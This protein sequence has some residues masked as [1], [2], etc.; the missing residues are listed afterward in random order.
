MH[1]RTFIDLFEADIS[2]L[3][4]DIIG[5]VRQTQDAQLLDKIYTVLNQSG[6]AERINGTLE[7]DTDTKG[8]TDTITQ[9]I[10]DTPG[11]FQQKHDFINGFPTGYVDIDKM[12]SGNR[13]KFTELLSGGKFVVDVFNRL[14][15]ETFGSAKGP[16]EFALAVMSPHIKINGKGDLTIGKNTIEV[17]ASAGKEASSGGG[18][19][20][21]P[22]LIRTDDVANIIQSTLKVQL[23]DV[24]PQG[25]G[26][27]GLGK[28]SSKLS[29]SQRR[30]FGKKLFGYMFGGSGADISDLVGAFASGTDLRDAYVKTNYNAYKSESDFD[31]VMIMNFALGELHYFRD[32]NDLVRH[33]YNGIG[34]YIVSSDTTKSSRQI[35]TQVTLAPFKEPTVELPNAPVDKVTPKLTKK[36][37][38]QVQDFAVDFARQQG[39]DDPEKIA[40]MYDVVMDLL[41]K[42]KDNKSVMTKLKKDYPKNKSVA[43]SPQ[44]APPSGPASAQQ[45]GRQPRQAQQPITAQQPIRARRSS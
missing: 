29:V 22:G 14:K 13:V 42:G 36:F 3:R 43:T 6:L 26:L 32:V 27:S 19:L 39:I 21:E 8:Y 11:T 15:R 23:S 10:I 12:L 38:L 1:M 24:A 5:Q 7:R 2:D 30:E 17:K 18:R 4:R 33:V 40:Q 35:L 44:P 45:A 20:G 41:A 31:G 37:E 28:L 34:V 9:I 16:G 25:V